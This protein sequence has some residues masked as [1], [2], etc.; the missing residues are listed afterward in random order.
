[1]IKA[2]KVPERWKLIFREEQYLKPT[3]INITLASKH[4]RK[5]FRI[6]LTEFIKFTDQQIYC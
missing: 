5:E 6:L 4:I 1:M 3:S 2:K